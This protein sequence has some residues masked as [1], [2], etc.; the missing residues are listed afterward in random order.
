MS[1]SEEGN[2]TVEG[3][4]LPLIWQPIDRLAWAQTAT[5]VVV[6]T[7]ELAA[8]AS[9]LSVCLGSTSH[10]VGG[11]DRLCCFYFLCSLSSRGTSSHCVR[12]HD[13]GGCS[14]GLCSLGQRR[15]RQPVCWRRG[16]VR[17]RLGRWF[18]LSAWGAPAT[19]EAG[20]TCEGGALASF[21]SF[22][23]CS[24]SYCDCGHVR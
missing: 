8:L 23:V 17:A 24:A 7:V 1:A 20:R 18:A 10:C 16:K 19:V 13:V 2:K 3:V 15:L 9:V 5:V 12:W 14:S 21:I 4:A 11:D 22:G 6:M